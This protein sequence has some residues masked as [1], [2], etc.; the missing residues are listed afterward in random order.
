VTGFPWTVGARKRRTVRTPQA[1]LKAIR[2]CLEASDISHHFERLTED[3]KNSFANLVLNR[4]LGER[5]DGAAQA[6][7]PAYDGHHY[8]PFP[9]LRIGPSLA[10]VV[11]CSHL[12][13]DAIDLPLAAVRPG[14]FDS[15]E[16]DD[17]R[18]C[19]AAWAGF[20]LPSDADVVIP[21]HP[22]QIKLS[23]IV[24]ELL[25]RRWIVLLKER[26]KA[27]PLA[28]QRT[29]RIVATGFDVKLAIDVT[30]TAE[31]RLLYPVN[32]ANAPAVSTLARLFLESSGESTLDFQRD[33]A[34]MAH[35]DPHTETHLAAIVRSP[36]PRGAGEIVVPA[37]NLW[38]GRR[39]AR[40][41][42]DVGHPE[43]AYDFFRAYCR[44]LMRGPVDFYARWG[45]AFEPHLQNVYVAFQDGAPS[46]IILRDLDGTILD[47]TRT[48]PVIRANCLRLAPSTWQHMPPFEIGG[49]RLVHAMLYG[50]LGAVMSYLA[51]H[52]R[53]DL[54]GLSAGLDDVWTE[55]IDAAPSPSSRRLVRELRA[56]STTVK[57]MLRVRLAR[58]AQMEF[59]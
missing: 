54:N 58:S 12:C 15:A 27:V 19:F 56:Q 8:Y 6:I 55:L 33:V 31:H 23:P 13:R 49:Q 21:L 40:N 14:R 38:S 35:D 2:R 43:Q 41:L 42:L 25:K 26:L 47:A 1:F 37:V 34:S 48:Q 51:R 44:V 24:G 18:R 32:R 53:A 3:F 7:E 57:A 9:A 30:L 29:C 17:H 39:Q 4:L 5:L 50:H 28:S 20:A 45:M 10:Q 16:F 22:W 46:H 59:R 52:A 11:E 36:V